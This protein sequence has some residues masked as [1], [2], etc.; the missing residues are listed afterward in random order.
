MNASVI[1]ALAALAGAAIGGFTSVLASLLTQRTQARA[2]WVVQEKL[3]RQ[4][5]YKEFIE[6]ASKCYTDALQNDKTDVP[7]LVGA[8]FIFAEE[9]KARG[10]ISKITD[11][12]QRLRPHDR[13][14]L[15]A[16]GA[17]LL[18]EVRRVKDENRPVE[19]HFRGGSCRLAAVMIASLPQSG[20]ATRAS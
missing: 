4:E 3:R 8:R 13:C 7:A 6:G 15:E 14:Y 19:P 18:H 16:L 20:A 17:V 1:S 12:I 10:T 5:L 2:T 9:S 11:L